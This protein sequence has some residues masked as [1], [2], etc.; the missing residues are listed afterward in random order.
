MSDV[1]PMW[2]RAFD[3]VDRTVSPQLEQMVRT[4]QFADAA[5]AFAH[6]QGQLQ[7]RTERVLRRSLHF[8]NLPA[9]SDIK[10]MSEQVASLERRVRDLSKQ[11][12]DA[13]RAEAAGER[14]Q[15]GQGGSA[16]GKSKQPDGP[17]EPPTA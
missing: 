2:R 17:G 9:G 14:P 11:L 16:R 8:W 15:R 10:R 7:R 12:E 13:T 1:Q 5:A 6:L 4:E 3:A